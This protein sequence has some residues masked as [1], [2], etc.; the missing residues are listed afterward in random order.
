MRICFLENKDGGIVFVSSDNLLKN[1][2]GQSAER[3]VVETHIP[4]LY[5]LCLSSV[6]C[7]GGNTS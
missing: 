1:I 2:T 3:I 6:F 7:G 5:F 4:L